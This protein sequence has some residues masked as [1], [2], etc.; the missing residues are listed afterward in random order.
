MFECHSFSETPSLHTDNEIVSTNK[1]TSLKCTILNIWSKARH[2]EEEEF[3]IKTKKE[4]FS[5]VRKISDLL[6]GHKRQKIHIF[7]EDYLMIRQMNSMQQ[8]ELLQKL[9]PVGF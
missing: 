7:T 1:N 3:E 8:K 6:P 9:K 4:A 5:S 2:S